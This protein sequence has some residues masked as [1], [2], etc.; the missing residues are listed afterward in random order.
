MK[1]IIPGLKQCKFT[2]HTERS[3]NDHIKL[4]V[5]TTY[6]GRNHTFSVFG[7]TTN[8][9]LVEN[10]AKLRIKVEN[11]FNQYMYACCPPRPDTIKDGETI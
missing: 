9:L 8:D 7:I 5:D 1:P 3:F 6:E 10:K 2:I 11:A 4:R